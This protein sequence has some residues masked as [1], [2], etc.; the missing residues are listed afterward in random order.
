MSIAR[1][2]NTL[3]S[4]SRLQLITCLLALLGV[5]TVFV[6]GLSQWSEEKALRV[7]REKAE[8]VL[9]YQSSNVILQLNKFSLITALVAKRPDVL[10]AFRQQNNKEK[11]WDSLA[12]PTRQLAATVSG[13][14][15]A[16]DVWLVDRQGLVFS[17]NH[18]EFLGSSVVQQPFYK[19][20]LQGRLGRMSDV[21]AEGRRIYILASPV[22]VDQ[23]VAGAVVARINVDV[24]EY[25]W[26]LLP[27]PIL[28]SDQN[29]RVLLSNVS[30]WRL[31]N[32]GD[33]LKI[34]SRLSG[35]MTARSSRTNST[36]SQ[37][38]RHVRV[39]NQ[40]DKAMAKRYLE[41][42]RYTPLLQ[43]RFHTLV[44]LTAVR[45]QKMTTATISGLVI[46]LCIVLLWIVFERHRRRI[47]RSRSQ[48]AFAL[49]LER[50]V[51]DRTRDLVDSNTQLASEVRERIAAEAALRATQDDLMQA[52]KLAGIGQLSTALAHEYNQPLAAIR[53]YAD[54]AQQLLSK[55][56][57]EAVADNLQRITRLTERM[58]N[59]TTTLRSFAHKSDDQLVAVNLSSVM[60]EMVILLSPQ[61]KKHGVNLHINSPVKDVVVTASHLRL[62]QVIINI[63]S[64]AID[65][66]QNEERKVVEVSWDARSTI[67]EIY[68][69]DSGRGISADVREKIF[70]PFFTTKGVGVGLGLGLFMAYNIVKSFSGSIDV[71]HEKNYGGVFRIT[72]PLAN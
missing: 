35:R 62:S 24:I 56:K 31:Q 48:R 30:D 12:L 51:R 54:N 3:Y 66:A 47:D 27:E 33:L 8:T 44:D 68:I 13:L 7:A 63:V 25:V 69:K 71:E 40:A 45:Q 2:P 1:Y 16:Q 43:W 4:L 18:R 65:A 22:F 46:A 6:Y 32:V 37:T 11:F 28:A 41:V 14:S 67:A 49:R 21:D 17:S 26:A 34:P 5:G 55:E 57:T 52:A 72:L 39:S 53:S 20:V 42:T 61:A 19:A 60:D 36:S 58:A 59:L 10:K 15:G 50:Q 38:V 9:N 29:G 23:K 70:T 64:N